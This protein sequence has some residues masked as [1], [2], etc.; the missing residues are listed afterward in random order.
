MLRPAWFEG[1]NRLAVSGGPKRVM[2][3]ADEPLVVHGVHHWIAAAEVCQIELLEDS[4][5]VV[6]VEGIGNPLL[7]L[8]LE[9]HLDRTTK[10]PDG[11]IR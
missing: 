4:P 9:P 10:K 2:R 11:Q 3:V 7:E 6:N 1:P 5:A 8:C